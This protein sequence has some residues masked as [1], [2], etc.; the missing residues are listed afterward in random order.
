MT[1]N[2]TDG[3]K[4]SKEKSV[5]EEMAETEETEEL[6]D[7]FEIN[8]ESIIEKPLIKAIDAEVKEDHTGDIPKW[9]QT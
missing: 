5:L 8:S 6:P 4:E 3:E 9:L 7:P 2:Q 1:E